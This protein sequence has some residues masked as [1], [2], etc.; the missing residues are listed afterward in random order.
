MQRRQPDRPTTRKEIVNVHLFVVTYAKDAPWLEWC[1]KSIRTF[2]AGF[3][4]TTVLAPHSDADVI[5]PM[6]EAYG[7]KLELDDRAGPPLGF[8][9]HMVQKCCADR[10]CPNAD[11]IVHIDSDTIFCAPSTPATFFDSGK[12][13]MVVEPYRALAAKGDQAASWLPSTTQMLGWEPQYETMRRQ[14]ATYPRGLY[15]AFREFI[16]T[17]HGK[18]F[19]EFML[20]QKATHP[21]GWSEFNCLGA[22]AQQRMPEQFRTLDVSRE[23]WPVPT[24]IQF[25]SVGPIDQPVDVWIVGKLCRVVPIVE[26][27]RILS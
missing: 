18:P 1:L 21:W 17:R 19:R 24:L 5:R 12:P 26:I 8:L 13:V 7:A 15:S 22:F 27:Q 25:W 2:A 6:C 3:S 14:G 16:E 20:S 10:W 4:G 11:Y 9:D 23:P